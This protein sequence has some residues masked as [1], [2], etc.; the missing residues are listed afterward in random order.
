VFYESARPPITA[1]PHRCTLA[2]VAKIKPDILDLVSQ[3]NAHLR[4][5][6]AQR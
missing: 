3:K 1:S 5:Q 4:N 6:T 2:V